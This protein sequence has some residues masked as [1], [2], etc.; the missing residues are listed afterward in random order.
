M[1]TG[2]RSSRAPPQARGV[3]T[4]GRAGL[5]LQARP[6]GSHA[7]PGRR[8]RVSEAWGALLR[9]PTLKPRAPRGQE[10]GASASSLFAQV[11]VPKTPRVLSSHREDNVVSPAT[12][13][14]QVFLRAVTRTE[15]RPAPRRPAPCRPSPCRPF[16][17]N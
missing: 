17:M 6:G 4:S 5:R 16:G 8:A 15:L 9:P 3:G 1:G 12:W 14:G 10:A 11:P 2:V 7:R 13:N